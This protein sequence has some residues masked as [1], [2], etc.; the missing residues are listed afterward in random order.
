MANQDVGAKYGYAAQAGLGSN[1]LYLTSMRIDETA[2]RSLQEVELEDGRFYDAAKNSHY[3][4]NADAGASLWSGSNDYQLLDK[5]DQFYLNTPYLKKKYPFFTSKDPYSMLNNAD[6]VMISSAIR[7]EKARIAAQKASKDYER[8]DHFSIGTVYLRIPPIQINVSEDAHNYRMATLRS[9]GETVFTSGRTT[10]RIELDIVFTGLDDIN[11]K[12]RPLMAQFKTTPFLPIENEYLRRILNPYNSKLI[13]K[14]FAS[15]LEDQKKI[16]E[17]RARKVDEMVASTAKVDDNHNKIKELIDGISEYIPDY[18]E[19]EAFWFETI[20][21]TSTIPRGSLEGEDIIKNR[22]GTERVDLA[23]WIKKQISVQG[24]TDVDFTTITRTLNEVSAVQDELDAI[25]KKIGDFGAEM[26]DERFAD[27]QLAAVL[28]Q[29]SLSVSPGFP[30]SIQCHLTLYVF[31]YEPF[32]IDFA[33]ISGY[34]KEAATP[35][36]TKCDFFIDWYTKRFLAYRND[37]EKPSLGSYEA[38]HNISLTYFKNLTPVSTRVTYEDLKKLVAVE[39]FNTGQG[40]YPV[41][42]TVSVKNIIQFLPILSLKSPTCQ[43]M[44]SLNSDVIINFE[45]TDD[46]KL[47]E[48]SKMVHRIRSVSRSMNRGTR[49]NFVYINNDLL[50][51]LAMPYFMIG[52]VTIDTVPGNPGLYSVSLGLTEHKVGQQKLEKLKREGVLGI[53]DVPNACRYILDKANEYKLGADIATAR[54]VANDKQHLKRYYEIVTDK[55]NGWF[56]DHNDI[57]NSFMTGTG[58]SEN[59][60]ELRDRLLSSV[61]TLTTETAMVYVGGVLVK[62]SGGPVQGAIK[63]TVATLS[64]S[65]SKN[66]ALHSGGPGTQ[67]VVIKDYSGLREQMLKAI[68]SST[69]QDAYLSY[70]DDIAHMASIVE[71]NTIVDMLYSPDFP[72]LNEKLN[73]NRSKDE[74]DTGKIYSYPDLDLP[75]FADLPNGFRLKNT[76]KE[77]GIPRAYGE[78]NKSIQS[79]SSE[80]DPDFYFYRGSLWKTVDDDNPSAIAVTNG[81]RTYKDIAKSNKGYRRTAAIDEIDM[82]NLLAEAYA[83][84]QRNRFSDDGSSTASEDRLKKL[85][86]QPVKITDVHDGDTY[87]AEIAG[88]TVKVRAEGYEAPEIATSPDGSKKADP[89][90]GPKATDKLRSILLNPKAQIR[91]LFNGRIDRR[92]MIGTTYVSTNEGRTWDSVG[93]MMLKDGKALGITPWTDHSNPLNENYEMAFLK[94]HE[95]YVYNMIHAAKG[96]SAAKK[97]D[98][99]WYS[100]VQSVASRS[101]SLFLFPA[102]LTNSIAAGIDE[103]YNT[104]ADTGFA[105]GKSVGRVGT[106]FGRAIKNIANGNRHNAKAVATSEVAITLGIAIAESKDLATSFSPINLENFITNDPDA[107]IASKLTTGSYVPN[108][109]FNRFDRESDT[110][111]DIISKKIRESQ[112]EDTLSMSRAYPT[113]KFYFMEEDMPEWGR[114]DDFYSY[115]AINNIS[116]TKSRTEA[117]DVAVVSLM[118]T[119]GTLDRS[120]YGLYDDRGMFIVRGPRESNKPKDQETRAEQTLEQFI[121]KP[122]TIIKIKM[123]YHSDPDLLD[124]VFIGMISEVSGGDMINIVAQGYGVELLH[125]VEKSMY[126]TQVA[127]AF[128][129][130]HKAITSPEVKHFGKLD[131]FPEESAQTSKV[132]RRSVYDPIKQRWI[133]SSWWRN[134]AGVRHILSVVDDQKDNNIFHPE[135]SWMYNMTFGGDQAFVTQGKTIWDLFREMQRRM[136]GYITTVLP[137]DNRATIYFGPADF[138][139]FY[140]SGKKRERGINQKKYTEDVTQSDEDILDDLY[141]RPGYRKVNQEEMNAALSLCANWLTRQYNSDDVDQSFKNRLANTIEQIKYQGNVKESTID[142]NNR[143]A[144]QAALAAGGYLSGNQLAMNWFSNFGA[145][146]GFNYATAINAKDFLNSGVSALSNGKTEEQ[147]KIT[148]ALDFISRNLDRKTDP[149][150]TAETK[151]GGTD[152]ESFEITYIKT[153]DLIMDP[154][155]NYLTSEDAINAYKIMRKGEWMASDPQR[156]PVRQ[157]HFKDSLHHIVS[158]NIIASESYLYNK[159]TVEFGLEAAWKSRSLLEGTPAFGKVS[160]QVDDDIWPEKIKEKVYQERNAREIVTAWNYALGNLSEDFRKM[161]SGHLTILGDPRIKPYDIIMMSDYFTEMF[162][163]IEV[164]QVTHHFSAETGFITTIVPNLVCH[165]NNAMQQGSLTVAGAYMDSTTELVQRIRTLS[166]GG[167]PIPIIGNAAANVSFW[168][169]GLSSG[170]REPIAFTPLAYAGRPYIA[171][172]EGMRQTSVVEAIRGNITRFILR[173]DRV[174]EAVTNSKDYLR[175]HAR[176]REGNIPN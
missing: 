175:I 56:C 119:I 86:W 121:L 29:M 59:D 18:H 125:N 6:T 107:I 123:G 154:D 78:D 54:G 101:S 9:P 102:G 135:N 15:N 81:I 61:P 30:D 126:W 26:K 114:L 124:D 98:S 158:N 8:E 74:Q 75:K 28:S 163:P 88:E 128:N 148:K 65:N 55:T 3:L 156:K 77:L 2:I 48:F 25:Q 133:G 173:K 159:V 146:K 172:V 72:D 120:Q 66:I 118:N 63:G 168:L 103:H 84:Q 164:E 90:N 14:N 176:E 109:D 70:A 165:V 89:I 38:K 5:T 167:L 50:S 51:F 10:T 82:T 104:A 147:V 110:E 19:N 145:Q 33:F 42:I 39:T 22:Y 131:W 152:E 47:T 117:A 43:Y 53:H 170:R 11:Y 62:S 137:Y 122:G 106:H 36:I 83:N 97:K 41:G 100:V 95:T 138:L 162:G 17:E 141:E 4:Y 139:Y 115:Q 130:L 143:L 153:D 105:M 76:N 149:L 91:V 140:T 80:V 60:K 99:L 45:C 27:R 21:D 58:S 161:Y 85:N 155:N 136:P 16:M 32:S 40:F 52:D 69:D 113:F 144:G 94:S 1:S 174:F 151:S 23:H 132:F 79:D 92:R 64:G 68:G 142:E 71:R 31:S 20:K 129:I 169:T 46:E 134:I 112:K 96:S 150:L 49:N 34:N 116:I 93:D 7:A 73:K 24:K 127:S 171:G 35:D 111:I 160:A 57:V 157:Y 67:V 37:I 166:T 87:T 13:D 108:N 12:L 44:G